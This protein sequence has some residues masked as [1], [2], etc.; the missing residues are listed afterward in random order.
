MSLPERKW[1]ALR[2]VFGRSQVQIQARGPA[3]LTE[4]FRGFSESLETNAGIVGYF[5]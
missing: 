1:L 2:F 5:K 3:F 4:V